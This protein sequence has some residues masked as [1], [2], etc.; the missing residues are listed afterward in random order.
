MKTP[1]II[2]IIIVMKI[3]IIVA[4]VGLTKIVINQL[5]FMN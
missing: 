1:N 3:M 4:V 5:I 2:K